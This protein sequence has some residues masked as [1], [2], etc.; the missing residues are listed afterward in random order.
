MNLIEVRCDIYG[1]I[2]SDFGIITKK[3]NK[4]YIGGSL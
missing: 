2:D 1:T 3:G 4:L